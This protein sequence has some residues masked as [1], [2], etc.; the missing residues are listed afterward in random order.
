MGKQQRRFIDGR[1]GAARKDGDVISF[2]ERLAELVIRGK[3]TETRRLVREGNELIDGVMYRN[4]RRKWYVGQEH[5]VCPG[6]GRPAYYRTDTLE[7]IYAD[8]WELAK[9]YREPG[10]SMA[11]EMSS[12]GY[13]PAR[14]RIT[15]LR[16]E[17]LR[18]ITD[19]S[20]LREGVACLWPERD[21]STHDRRLRA[22]VDLWDSTYKRSGT[23]WADNPA[24]WV[25]QF[26]FL[27]A[28]I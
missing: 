6:R 14:L 18:A 27:G 9:Y 2:R 1:G 24:V 25:I 16:Q 5:A 20:I 13:L 8:I 12:H 11:D 10:Y 17:L 4:G 22:W 15:G 21:L 28:A 23:R 7:F 26:E 3:K 19:A